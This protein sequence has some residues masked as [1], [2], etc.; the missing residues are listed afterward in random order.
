MNTF[1]DK[2]TSVR[3]SWMILS[4]GS[5]S[6][7]ETFRFFE[8]ISMLEIRIGALRR[9]LVELAKCENS[10]CFSNRILDFRR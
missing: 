1:R 8:N 6:R 4:L 2:I 5:G 10:T 7:I 3:N 9:T